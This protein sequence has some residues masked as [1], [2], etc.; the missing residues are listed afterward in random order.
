MERFS[1]VFGWTIIVL[2]ILTMPLTYEELHSL[3]HFQAISDAQVITLHLVA[4]SHCCG[5]LF[6]L[7]L[8]IMLA[9]SVY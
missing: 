5:G 8:V 2:M 4:E 6:M 9:I 7:L 3:S 1:S